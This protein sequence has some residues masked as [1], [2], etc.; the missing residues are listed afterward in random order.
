MTSN[1]FSNGSKLTDKVQEKALDL[2]LKIKP[3]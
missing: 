1:R 3:C 2:I